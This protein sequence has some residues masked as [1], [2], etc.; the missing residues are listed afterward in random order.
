[1]GFF[2]SFRSKGLRDNLFAVAVLAV[3]ALVAVAEHFA[4][5]LPA[6]VTSRLYAR[7]LTNTPAL[8]S[9]IDTST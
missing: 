8:A 7:A 9:V 1:P 3:A 4:L 6:T 5:R 2:A